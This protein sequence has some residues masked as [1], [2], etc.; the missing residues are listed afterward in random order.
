VKRPSHLL[1]LPFQGGLDWKTL[2]G[3]PPQGWTGASKK[4]R[5]LSSVL[6]DPPRDPDGHRWKNADD[7]FLYVNGC[8]DK[9]DRGE[10]YTE[11][12]RLKKKCSSTKVP[13]Q[14]G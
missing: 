4:P 7:L 9:R 12:R 11:L 13:E 6:T 1:H 5:P 10:F 2:E 3:T 14:L 8:S